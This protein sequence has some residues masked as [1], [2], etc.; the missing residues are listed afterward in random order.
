[1]RKESRVFITAW[2]DATSIRT[3][4]GEWRL[5]GAGR[6]L[7]VAVQLPR[8]TFVHTLALNALVTRL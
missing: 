3:A 6:S 2:R 7:T 5:E 4:T 1:M 8:Q